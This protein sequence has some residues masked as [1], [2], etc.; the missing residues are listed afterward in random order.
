MGSRFQL[1][2]KPLIEDLI[3]YVCGK[4]ETQEIRAR[5]CLP[6]HFLDNSYGPVHK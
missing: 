3:Q 4:V 5:H 6:T 2:R 1:V